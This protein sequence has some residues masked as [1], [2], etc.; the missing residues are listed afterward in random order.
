MKRTL[1]VTGRLSEATSKS[2]LTSHTW[3]E[4]RIAS[5]RRLLPFLLPEYILQVL[6]HLRA[7]N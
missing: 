2:S 3:L 1:S 4:E 7:A 6:L 5:A